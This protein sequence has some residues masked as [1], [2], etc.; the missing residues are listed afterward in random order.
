MIEFFK[1]MSALDVITCCF[2]A[3][4]VIS[5]VCLMAYIYIYERSKEKW[6]T[7]HDTTTN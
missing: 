2:S 4:I 6:Q 7:E 1:G 5:A 3:L